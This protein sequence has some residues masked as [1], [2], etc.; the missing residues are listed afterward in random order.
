M[1]SDYTKNKLAETD[2]VRSK[3]EEDNESDR[4]NHQ[5]VIQELYIW[6]VLEGDSSVGFPKGL[7]CLFKEYME[8]KNWSE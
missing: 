6:Q 1:T 7:I 5:E 2:F 4:L 8:I 3:T